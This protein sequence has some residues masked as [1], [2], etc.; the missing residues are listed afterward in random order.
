MSSPNAALIS[1]NAIDMEKLNYPILP[2]ECW[3]HIFSFFNKSDQKHMSAVSTYFKMVASDHSLKN[4]PYPDLDYTLMLPDKNKKYLPPVFS[5]ES[6]NAWCIAVLSDKHFVTASDEGIIRVWDKNY[7]NPIRKYEYY[8][9]QNSKLINKLIKLTSTRFISCGNY[10]AICLWDI[11]EKKPLVEFNKQE[12]TAI[13]E[14]KIINKSILLT[15]YANN[16]LCIWDIAT[17]NCISTL[18]SDGH[19]SN[20]GL[21]QIFS[22]DLVVTIS[23]NKDRNTSQS[24]E[25]FLYLWDLTPASIKP[26]SFLIGHSNRITALCKIDG[27]TLVSASVDSTLRIWNIDQKICTKVIKLP[28]FV[29]VHCLTLLSSGLLACGTID[30][31]NQHAPIYLYD[32]KQKDSLVMELEGHHMGIIGEHSIINLQN[33][34]FASADINGLIK[35][36][37]NSTKKC[38]QTFET[39]GGIPTLAMLSNGY[40]INVNYYDYLINVWAFAEK[41]FYTA[42]TFN[43]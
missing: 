37:D 34:H 35:I 11:R 38:L 26:L 4:L 27:M 42:P 43:P 22:P 30:L 9:S 28:S 2:D 32:L 15:L 23:N 19:C 17:G 13:I 10:G 25:N 24:Y 14:A 21:M 5:N 8:T 12:S 16:K 36:W 6:K 7:A 33:N 3:L 18:N 20:F 1:K 31:E 41:N 39:E 29:E 40:L